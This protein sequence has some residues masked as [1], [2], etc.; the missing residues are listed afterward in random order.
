MK[1]DK[2]FT[3]LAIGGYD[4]EEVDPYIQKLE[5]LLS[6]EAKVQPSRPEIPKDFLQEF[7]SIQGE[8]KGYKE[9]EMTLRDALEA[10]HKATLD[11]QEVVD[12]E[13]RH[14]LYEANKNADDIIQQALEQS[15]SALNYI[16]KMRVDARVFQKR[17]KILLAAQNE[18]SD[19][20]LWDEVLAPIEPY[21]VIKIN[22]I[23]DILN[24]VDE[25]E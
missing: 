20:N 8:L 16:K 3:K 23:D 17:F 22:T 4:P 11:I 5:K 13:A 18:F 24:D 15:I 9:I 14:I 25:N 6:V 12:Q 21:D 7:Q 19:T 2:E 10:A 1:P